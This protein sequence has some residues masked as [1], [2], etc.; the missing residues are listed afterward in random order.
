[1][2]DLVGVTAARGGATLSVLIVVMV[3][4]L[5]VWQITSARW[6]AGAEPLALLLLGATLAG[7]AS[8]LRERRRQKV[9]APPHDRASL[10]RELHHTA[11]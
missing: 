1:M 5:G 8:A 10:D 3:A 11:S 2:K 4:G 7:S 6:A 9:D